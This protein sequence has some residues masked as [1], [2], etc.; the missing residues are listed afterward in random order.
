MFTKSTD[1]TVKADSI[2]PLYPV[3]S[4]CLFIMIK[5]EIERSAAIEAEDI[6]LAFAIIFPAAE[7]PELTPICV[8]R[9]ENIKMFTNSTD[10][11]VKA[12]SIIPLYPVGSKCLFIMIRNEIERSAA[13]EAEDIKLA[14]AIIFPAAEILGKII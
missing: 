11:T 2:I 6:K 14:F 7:I 3:G 5:N 13:I 10:K 8:P 12:D 9:P 4:K 1:K